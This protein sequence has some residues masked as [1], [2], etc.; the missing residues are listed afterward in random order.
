[1]FVPIRAFAGIALALRLV[2]GSKEF[3]QA[4]RQRVQLGT[5][6]ARPVLND[7]M[8]DY[9]TLKSGE[10]VMVTPQVFKNVQDVATMPLYIDRPC[11]NVRL[12]TS[13]V[14]SLED[15]DGFSLPLV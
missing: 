10:Q 3:E 9:I 1:V 14:V 15:V 11:P 13:R 6:R 12:S 8:K 2:A 5:K 4:V 7:A